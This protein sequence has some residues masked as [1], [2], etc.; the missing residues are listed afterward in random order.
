MKR[1]RL[2]PLLALLIVLFLGTGVY[3]LQTHFT[4]RVVGA[5]DFFPR[6]KGAQLFLKEGVNPYSEEATAAIQRDMYGRLARPDE[7]QVAFAYPFYTIFLLSPLVLLNLPYSWVQAI[8]LVA[9]FAGLVLAVFTALRLVRWRPPPWLLALTVLWAIL[10]YNGLRTVILGQFAAFVFLATAGCV[11]ALRKGRDVTA[12]VLL[13]TTTIKPQMSFLLI[14]ALLL[15]ALSQRRWRFFGA[16]AASISLLLGVSFLAEPFWLR[17][18]VLQIVNY[19][20]YTA[21]GSPVWIV[22]NYYF[23]GLGRATEIGLSLLLLAALAWQWRQLPSAAATSQTF[24]HVVFVTLLVTELIAPRTAT[25]NQTVLY[26]LIFWAL[27]VL[28]E[29]VDAGKILTTLFYVLS[30]VGVWSVFLTTRVG[31]FEQ[32]ATFLMVPSIAA[33]M[34]LGARLL[35]DQVLLHKP[36]S[37]NAF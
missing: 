9:V 26:L 4:S 32:P 14:P 37:D 5:N 31:D 25:T 20:D 13:A 29:Q 23:P 19:V 12:G 30:F 17:D 1:G 7:D 2:K 8:W 28:Q 33:A 11:L 34:Y 36:V 24:L 3:L 21:F 35:A 10:S 15:W 16:F 6:W 27:K 18:F 22:T